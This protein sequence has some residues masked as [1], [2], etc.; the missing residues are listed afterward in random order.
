MVKAFQVL[1]RCAGLLHLSYFFFVSPITCFAFSWHSDAF[2]NL[3]RDRIFLLESMACFCVMNGVLSA[4][5]F[6]GLDRR[7]KLLFVLNGVAIA[8]SAAV[9]FLFYMY[10]RQI[11]FLSQKW[12]MFAPALAS[13][14]ILMFVVACR[15]CFNGKSNRVG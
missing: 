3:D 6:V 4:Y 8:L 2:V 1:S 7:L 15:K 5:F 12:Q 13:N 10:C 11:G 9:V 14:W